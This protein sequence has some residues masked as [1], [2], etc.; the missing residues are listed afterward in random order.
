MANLKGQFPREHKKV[1]ASK[2]TGSSPN[3]PAWLNKRRVQKRFAYFG[4]FF[5]LVTD[6]IP[7][8]FQLQLGSK[9]WPYS[10][11]TPS[12]CEHKALSA[13]CTRT[14]CV[15]VDEALIERI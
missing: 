15:G 1:A 10:L 2:K 12:R 9:T 13:I 3:K 14:F 7:N 11:D 8:T 4:R 6:S 5:L